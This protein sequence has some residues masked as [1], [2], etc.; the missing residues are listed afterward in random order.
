MAEIIV[1]KSAGFCFG[2]DR[3]V[4]MVSDLVERGVRVCTLG[5]I[6][7]NPQM[8]EKLAARGVRIAQSPEDRQDGETMVIRT[9]GV[10]RDVFDRV[11]V[12]PFADATCPYVAN[13]HRLVETAHEEGRTVLIAGDP[14]HPEVRGIAGRAGDDHHVFEDDAALRSILDLCPDLAEKPVTVVCQTTFNLAKWMICQKTLKKVCT[15]AEIFDT[16]CRATSLRQEETEA[17]SRRCD[18][19]IVVGGRHSSNTDKLREISSAH[20]PRTFLIETAGEL[21]EDMIRGA[22]VIGIT[23]GAST[24]SEIIKEVLIVM[25]EMETTT[26]TVETEETVEKSFDEMTFEE[27]MEASL[28]S[29]NSDQKVK[30]IVLAVNPTEIQVDIGRK[31]TG[32]V[33]AREFSNDPNLD[34]TQAV[35]VG[36]VLDLIIL[37]TNDQEG[38]VTLSKR[39][40]DSIAGWDKIVE[41]KESGEVLEGTVTAFASLFLLL[42]RLRPVWSPLISSRALTSG[43]G[44]LRSIAA[45]VPLAPFVPSFVTSARKTS[46]SFLKRPRSARR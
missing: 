46:P 8:V 33:P 32:F 11:S 18:A 31:Q 2:V 21:T 45:V 36:D 15:N 34:L 44:S 38:T 30:G 10:S 19:M 4:K 40:Y 12:G 13:I 7:H 41:A 28:N 6:I 23:A 37:R 39:R 29:M 35:K 5:P 42:R 25:S 14:S 9:H 17:L 43:S 20:C 26:Q 24:P 1:A 3:A 16:I 22:D 27:A